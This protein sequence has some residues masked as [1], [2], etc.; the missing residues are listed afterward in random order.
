MG[1]AD[2]R[3]VALRPM[4][5]SV[6]L[7]VP[8]F[9]EAKRLP[10]VWSQVSGSPCPLLFVNDGSTDTTKEWLESHLQAPHQALHLAC[11]VGKAEAVRQGMLYLMD[12]KRAK[13]LEWAGYWDADFSAPLDEVRRLL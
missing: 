4:L 8:C 5:S 12:Q 3:F 13:S 10:R 1:S 9:N 2:R 6:C 7:V 11:N